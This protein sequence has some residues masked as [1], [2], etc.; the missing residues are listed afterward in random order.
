MKPAIQPTM[1]PTTKSTDESLIFSVSDHETLERLGREMKP[2]WPQCGRVELFLPYLTA[3]ENV[4]YE[5]RLNHYCATKGG[6]E[7]WLLTCATSLL[8]LLGFGFSMESTAQWLVLPLLIVGA[9]VTG[10]LVGLKAMQVRRMRLVAELLQRM[11]S[12]R[13]ACKNPVKSGLTLPSAAT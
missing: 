6:A 13:P 7:A 12:P 5:K 11:P 4:R 1:K 3:A 2:L 9:F 8:G 10:K